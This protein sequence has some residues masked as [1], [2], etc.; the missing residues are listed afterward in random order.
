MASLLRASECELGV[1]PPVGFWPHPTADGNVECFAR[2]RRAI[3]KGPLVSWTQIVMHD[4]AAAGPRA[5]ARR[6]AA[7]RFLGPPQPRGP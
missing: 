1:R 5:R 4:L 3:S 6:A 2:R 7:R